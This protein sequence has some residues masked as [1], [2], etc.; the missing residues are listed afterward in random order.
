MG[1]P[2]DFLASI[3][4]GG[5]ISAGSAWFCLTSLPPD[6]PI[7]CQAYM[8]RQLSRLMCISCTT[9]KTPQPKDCWLS[10]YGVL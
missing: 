5:V 7:S 10:P 1:F 2:G 9:L 4:I 8:E 6:I 3:F